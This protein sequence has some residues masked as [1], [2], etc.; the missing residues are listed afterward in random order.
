MLLNR[1]RVLAVV[2]AVLLAIA[3]PG[4]AQS[5]LQGEIQGKIIDSAGLSSPGRQ[6]RQPGPR[7]SGTKTVVSE[8]DG[9]YRIPALPAGE[10]YR[11]EYSLT[12]FRTVIR[13]G[14]NVNI[15]TATTLDITLEVATLA[16]SVTVTG[17]SPLIDV[18]NTQ[19][20]HVDLANCCRRFPRAE[21]FYTLM[22]MTPGTSKN[23][24]SVGGAAADLG[25]PSGC[26]RL[27]GSPHEHQWRRV[28]CVHGRWTLWQLRRV[29]G[30]RHGNWRSGRCDA[31]TRWWF[32][33]GDG[34]Q[35][36]RQHGPR[37]VFRVL[38]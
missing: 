8:F 5:G 28:V 10:G 27:V 3:S 6:S 11:I 24:P 38:V 37:H 1:V 23:T 26:G 29:R 17:E 22:V 12:G 2:V 31:P 34:G 18:A 33:R 14:I 9:T 15:R 32:S 7:S 16:E 13:T 20:G 4:L 19:P 21:T 35:D 25:Y 36:R 30:S